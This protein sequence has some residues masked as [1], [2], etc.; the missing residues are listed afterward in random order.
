MDTVQQRRPL[1]LSWLQPATLLA[2]TGKK[3]RVGFPPSESFARDSLMRPVQIGFLE[4]VAEELL[5]QPM[6]YE[7]VLDSSLKVPAALDM[8]LE[9][10][11]EAPPPPK[12]VQAE[13]KLETKAAAPAPA[14]APKAEAA[15]GAGAVAPAAEAAPA[16]TLDPDF[17]NDPLIQSAMT[18]FKAK[19]VPAG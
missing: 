19:L 11:D 5:G 14:G 4:G 6:K 7:F 13:V 2:I 3:I 8:P 10:P 1:F 12:P 18:R 16:P 9:F 15:K 17:Y